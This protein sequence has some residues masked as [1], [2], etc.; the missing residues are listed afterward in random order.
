M[1]SLICRILYHNTNII[2]L[3]LFY[4]LDNIQSKSSKT[5]SAREQEKC[6]SKN[7][8]QKNAG[9]KTD[10]NQFDDYEIGESM[11]GR[12]SS[13]P[14]PAQGSCP[15][16]A[17]TPNDV[18]P[19]A[20]SCFDSD[21]F[22]FTIPD[23]GTGD[24]SIVVTTDKTIPTSV[25]YQ[26]EQPSVFAF[27]FLDEGYDSDPSPISGYL[28]VERFGSTNKFGYDM[29]LWAGDYY[30]VVFPFFLEGGKCGGD[31]SK[32][33]FELSEGTL[34]DNMDMQVI[35]SDGITVQDFWDYS[36]D[37]YIPEDGFSQ[38]VANSNDE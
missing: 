13:Y 17:D 23:A 8:Y 29:T 1:C 5:C 27:V 2:C 12:I 4:L 16:V 28:T 36:K 37:T 14:K 26:N 19:D 30:I 31:E 33:N 7:S 21:T 34:N 6:V 20:S 32:Y 11:C 22:R 10:L 3:I 25:F 38:A 18:N 35:T 15:F 9:Y 24:Y